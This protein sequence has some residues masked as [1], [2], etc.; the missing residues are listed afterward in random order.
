LQ[1]LCWCHGSA[2]SPPC[3]RRQLGCFF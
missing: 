1:L 3:A 2:V